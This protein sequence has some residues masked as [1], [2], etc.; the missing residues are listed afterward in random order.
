MNKLRSVVIGLFV[1]ILLFL[2]IPFFLIELILWVWIKLFSL[3]ARK[4]KSITGTEP[5]GAKW[6]IRKGAKGAIWVLSKVKSGTRKYCRLKLW[7][8]IKRKIINYFP[9]F[10]QKC[11]EVYNF[12]SNF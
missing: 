7:Y 6:V 3:P 2:L 1:L 5:I 11:R 4:P 9:R 10:Y 8:Y 12:V